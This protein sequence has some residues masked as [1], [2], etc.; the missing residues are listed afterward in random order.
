MLVPRIVHNVSGRILPPI[1]PAGHETKYSWNWFGSRTRLFHMHFILQKMRVLLPTCCRRSIHC[2]EVHHQCAAWEDGG[3]PGVGNWWQWKGCGMGMEE[4]GDKAS[5]YGSKFQPH[6][7]QC[8]PQDQRLCVWW[9]LQLIEEISL[10]SVGIAQT[11]WLINTTRQLCQLL[12]DRL[13]LTPSNH[14]LHM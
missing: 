10:L 4:W 7:I 8:K 6:W 12:A 11:S 1:F 3:S 14:N 5:S 13:I 2:G 9:P